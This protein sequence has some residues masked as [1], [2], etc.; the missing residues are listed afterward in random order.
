LDG[1]VPE[2]EIAF[3][4]EPEVSIA[5][6]A[7]EGEEGFVPMLPGFEAVSPEVPVDRIPEVRAIF[8]ITLARGERWELRVTISP[9]PA[10]RVPISAAPSILGQFLAERATISTDNP[11]FNRIL[12]RCELDL[13]A[14][15]TSFPQGPLPAAGIPWFVA[16]FGRDSLIV[17]L[18]TLHLLPQRAASTLRVLAALQGEQVDPWR[19]EEP[20]KIL[21]EMRYGE[22]A[23]CGEVPHTPYY[24]S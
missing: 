5:R 6:G 1:L 11:F 19:G 13:A 20:G 10:N 21:H 18:Q 8:P 4:R 12:Q 22:M 23:R 7:A 3:D 15:L 9:I 17:G 14:L 2:T 24:G 16:P